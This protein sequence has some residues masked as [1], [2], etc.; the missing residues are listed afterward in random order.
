[1]TTEKLMALVRREAGLC[2]DLKDAADRV[3]KTADKVCLLLGSPSTKPGEVERAVD[4][5]SSARVALS[6]TYRRVVDHAKA[7]N[8]LAA[9][10][11]E[12]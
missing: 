1:M 8:E 3:A 12:G 6:A 2:Y 11:G 4:A 5:H 7:M 9:P 10:A